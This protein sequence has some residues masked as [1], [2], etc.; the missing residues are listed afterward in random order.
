MSNQGNQPPAP[1]APPNNRVITLDNLQHELLHSEEFEVRSNPSPTAIINTMSRLAQFINLF[2]AEALR[3]KVISAANPASAGLMNA[4]GTLE[5]G[6]IQLH[7]LVQQQQQGAFAGPGPQG[8]Q[9]GPF[10][11]N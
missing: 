9:S 2:M 3:S 8:S 4:S 6:A 5:Q 10:R 7:A 1:P 11:M